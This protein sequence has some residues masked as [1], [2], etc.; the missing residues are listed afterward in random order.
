MNKLECK[1]RTQKGFLF[2]IL[3]LNM[4]W[5]FKYGLGSEVWADL[6]HW[7]YLGNWGQ[8]DLSVSLSEKMA[9]TNRFVFQIWHLN[10]LVAEH[11][12]GDLALNR[13]ISPKN[14][15]V[16]GVL[17][18]LRLPYFKWGMRFSHDLQLP[19]YFC[20][21]NMFGGKSTLKCSAPHTCKRSVLQEN[22]I[23]KQNPDKMIRLDH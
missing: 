7:K 18:K 5:T 23:T 9:P 17:W 15:Y 22:Q 14:I 10:V 8:M 1:E 21:K 12:Y 19:K 13:F 20:E 3:H 4:G 2:Q 16:I 6:F 11:L